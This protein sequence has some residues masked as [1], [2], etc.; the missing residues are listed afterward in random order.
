MR[1]WQEPQLSHDN[2]LQI[3]RKIVKHPNKI[4]REDFIIMNSD[5]KPL[6]TSIQI[7]RYRQ[8]SRK[9]SYRTSNINII[10]I[11][12]RI[13]IWIIKQSYNNILIEIADKVGIYNYLCWNIIGEAG[14]LQHCSNVDLMRILI[15]NSILD[16]TL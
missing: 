15:R 14:G 8:N 16:M 13:L 9:S 12:A 11:F 10:F 5:T 6:L 7:L 4:A 3:R 1:Y 2:M